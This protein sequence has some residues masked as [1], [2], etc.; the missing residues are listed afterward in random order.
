MIIVPKVL[1]LRLHFPTRITRGSQEIFMLFVAPTVPIV[2]T[3]TKIFKWVWNRFQKTTCNTCT[4]QKRATYSCMIPQDNVRY[5]M[6]WQTVIYLPLEVNS[7]DIEDN[8][9]QPEDHKQALREGTVPD[10][11]SINSSLFTNTHTL[12][13]SQA[14]I[15][16]SYWDERV[17]TVC[18]CVCKA[19]TGHCNKTPG[20]TWIIHTA[21]ISRIT[22]CMNFL[23]LKYCSTAAAMENIRMHITRCRHFWSQ[24]IEILSSS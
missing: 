5:D 12:F 2:C 14:F 19:A 17:C 16:S 6:K 8:T 10:A 22:A 24:E 11:L 7:C 13:N 18:V 20:P 21:S 1:H 4:Q 9:F 3:I 15:A 23:F